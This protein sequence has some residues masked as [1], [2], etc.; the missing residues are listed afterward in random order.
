MEI[1]TNGGTYIKPDFSRHLTVTKNGIVFSSAVSQVWQTGLI[2]IPLLWS[3]LADDGIRSWWQSQMKYLILSIISN[4]QINP[5][6]SPRFDTLV[7]L[8]YYKYDVPNQERVFLLVNQSTI[9]LSRCPDNKLLG[10]ALMRSIM[11]SGIWKETLKT[12]Q[13]S[14]PVIMSSTLNFLP[15][16][17]EEHE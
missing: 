1:Y 17:W 8:L 14:L 13:S 16:K 11:L 9:F 3:K 12:P 4:F 7:A 5:T 15:K 10:I 2:S 6:F